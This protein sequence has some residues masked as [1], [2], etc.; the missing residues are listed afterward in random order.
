MAA[1][2]LRV[3]TTTPPS[4]L[5]YQGPA[6]NSLRATNTLNRSRS[7][8]NVMARTLPILERGGSTRNFRELPADRRLES[9]GSARNLQ[10]I[11]KR[12]NSTRRFFVAE[13]NARGSNTSNSSHTVTAASLTNQFRRVTLERSDSNSSMG[14]F[15]SWGSHASTMCS[16]SNCNTSQSNHDSILSILSM[17]SMAS[18]AQAP[19]SVSDSE[20]DMMSLYSRDSV[21]VR[22]GQL[23]VNNN[24]PHGSC[25]EG[26]ALRAEDDILSLASSDCTVVSF[27]RSAIV[28]SAL[29]VFGS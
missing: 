12:S 3:A 9:T 18:R 8:R 11:R 19:P 14:S 17:E 23:E 16:S 26:I 1:T 29:L 4:Y 27:D 25:C 10:G 20:D 21:K 22:L 5:D 6:M 28:G 15:Q 7:A 2:T 24:Y 13:Q